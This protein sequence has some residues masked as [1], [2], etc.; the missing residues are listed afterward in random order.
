MSSR[1]SLPSRRARRAPAAL[2][3]VA[4]AVVAGLGAPA[5]ARSDKTLAYRREEVWPTAVRFLVV[6]ERA[7]V[8]DKDADAGY[9]VFELREDKKTV[10]GSLEL[11][12]VMRDGRPAVQLVLQLAERPSWVEIAMLRRL[13]AKLRAELGAPAPP[14]AKEPPREPPA[15]EPPADRRPGDAPAPDPGQPPAAPADD[16]PLPISPTP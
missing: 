16:H 6:D 9:V 7:R 5:D 10:R 11:A 12:T 14:P 2:A 8:T 13:E 1:A 15:K 3:A 4:M